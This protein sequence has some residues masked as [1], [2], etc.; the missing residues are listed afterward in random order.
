M[1]GPCCPAAP[2]HHSLPPPRPC[3]PA[4]LRH[5][6]H[7]PRAQTLCLYVHTCYAVS[8]LVFHSLHH[9]RK[10][11]HASCAEYLWYPTKTHAFCTLIHTRHG[12][13]HN[14]WYVVDGAR[15][16][17]CVTPCR[18]VDGA[19][20]V[21]CV[22]P[23]RGVDGARG[24]LEGSAGPPRSLKWQLGAT[25]ASLAGL[26]ASPSVV[27][28]GWRRPVEVPHMYRSAESRGLILQSSSQRLTSC[29]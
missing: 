21:C 27:G 15:A 10:H 28:G 7:R 26:F 25:S 23:C 22:T 4:A 16:V 17:C 8:S 3:P 5:H 1:A 12:K 2:R 20:A 19:R 14:L 13:A 18:G 29:S 24:Q 11:F 9:D 6:G